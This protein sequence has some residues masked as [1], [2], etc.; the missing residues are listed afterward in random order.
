MLIKYLLASNVLYCE[1]ELVDVR[2]LTQTPYGI[3]KKMNEI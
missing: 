2:K 1:Q 3:E